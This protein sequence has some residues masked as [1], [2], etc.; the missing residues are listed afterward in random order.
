MVITNWIFFKQVSNSETTFDVITDDK[1]IY[2]ESEETV[3]PEHFISASDVEIQVNLK[4]Y[5]SLIL[6]GYKSNRNVRFES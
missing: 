1:P 5:L 6:G 2:D 4:F 3:I